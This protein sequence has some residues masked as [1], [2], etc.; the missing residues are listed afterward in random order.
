MIPCL[1]ST[2]ALPML[3]V[4]I[5]AWLPIPTLMREHRA[6]CIAMAVRTSCL[7]LLKL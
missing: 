5:K 6:A 1:A 4:C 2:K 7:L 3:F